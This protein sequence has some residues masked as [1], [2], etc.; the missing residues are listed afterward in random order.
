MLNGI[1]ADETR[2]HNP[3]G[4]PLHIYLIRTLSHLLYQGEISHPLNFWDLCEPNASRPGMV[5]GFRLLPMCKLRV[6]DASTP[7]GVKYRTWPWR[8]TL[9]HV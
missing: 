5:K 4:V 6:T 3:S 2:L 8:E 9:F 7:A 1:E